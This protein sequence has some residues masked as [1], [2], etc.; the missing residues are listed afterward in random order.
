MSDKQ[1]NVYSYL[2][3]EAI[4]GKL[5]KT[6]VAFERRIRREFA[7]KFNISFEDTFNLAWTDIVGHYYD[8]QIE[9]TPF[10]LVFNMAIDNYVPEMAEEEEQADQAFAESLVEEQ[11]A[12][13]AKQK[14]K[15]L[16]KD[17]NIN[18]TD[19]APTP[20]V[21]K[22]EPLGANENNDI[23]MNFDMRN[24]DEE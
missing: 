4:E 6:D 12:T 8:S 23:E 5:L 9:E 10:N 3:L 21:K 22:T 2:Q 16:M 1:F 14:S 18:K 17:E 7:F 19:T 15:K 13:L 20:S 24:P 11:K